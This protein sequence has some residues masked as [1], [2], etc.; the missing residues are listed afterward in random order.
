MYTGEGTSSS[1]IRPRERMF[2]AKKIEVSRE[3][4]TFD[5]KFLETYTWNARQKGDS[6]ALHSGTD[7]V[8]YDATA[9]L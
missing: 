2:W 1:I 9:N 6:C 5:R 8:F 4:R 7:S 3:A